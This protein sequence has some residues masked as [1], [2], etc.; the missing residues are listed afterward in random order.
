M[1]PL[2]ATTLLICFGGGIFGAALGG[3]Y[4]FI[5]VGL[6]VFSGCLVVLGGGSDFIL[7]Q[8]GLGPIF[9]VYAGGFS[10]GIVA[11]TYAAG[12]RKN[13]PNDSAK[14]IL[15]PLMDTSWDV[16]LVGGL[17][18]VVAQVL[19]QVL[20][21]I[22]IVNMFD[23]LA[24]TIVILILVA[25]FAF[26]KE[27]PW[28]QKD[29]IKE[30]GYIIQKDTSISWVPWMLPFEKMAIYGLGVGILSASLAMGTKEILDPMASAGT[31]SKTGAFVVPLIMG[32]SIAAITLIGLNFATGSIQKFPVWHCQAILAALAFMYWD[33]IVIGA[34][35]G[36]LAAFLQELMARMFYNHGS[37]HTDPPAFGIAMGTFILN[38]INR[39]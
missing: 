26:Q 15:S 36:M 30:H 14:D 16:L 18:A 25:R 20:P 29:S 1:E 23:S 21:K 2:S 32:W 27:M 34:V 38:F 11:A 4:S 17:T 35:V 12:V 6:I 8:V 22:P 33:S 24:L 37:N 13:H 28:G 31:I 9:G 19:L 3:L 5:L 39:I 10:S 7:M